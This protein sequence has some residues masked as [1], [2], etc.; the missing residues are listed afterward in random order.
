MYVPAGLRSRPE[1][2][3]ASTRKVKCVG[4]CDST[5]LCIRARRLRAELPPA[6]PALPVAAR[7]AS[8]SPP[9]PRSRAG[10][11]CQAGAVRSLM[12]FIQLSRL[13][14]RIGK[15]SPARLVQQRSRVSQVPFSCGTA[16]N[17]LCGANPCGWWRSRRDVSDGVFI[18]KGE[19]AWGRSFALST[20]FGK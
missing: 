7:R 6:P 13:A 8:R 16:P 3:F 17:G 9:N 10:R 1:K 11:V 20:G 5:D 4:V 2:R 15:A 14:V 18:T 12:S 19:R